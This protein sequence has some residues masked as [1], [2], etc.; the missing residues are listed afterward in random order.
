LLSH[1]I[2]KYKYSLLGLSILLG[3][4]AAC[5][6]EKNTFI[7]R[8]YHSTT[9]KYNGYWNARELIRV[10]LR[11]YRNNYK[12]D[13]YAI[14]PLDLL[15][16]EEDVVDMYPVLDTAISKCMTVISKHS[17][18]TASKPAKKK[19]EYAKW[20]D[21]NWLLIGKSNFYRRDYQKALDNFEFVRKFYGNRSSMYEGMLWKAKCQIELGDI[22]EAKRT[23]QILD[24]NF[25]N[26]LSQKKEKDTSSSKSKKKSKDDD[27]SLPAF[28][29]HLH[30][31]IAKTKAHLALIEND[32]TKAIRFLED[33]IKK[34]KVK[35]EKARL[36]F[37]VGQLLQ[38][39]DDEAAREYYTRAIKL[40]APFEMSFHAKINRATVGGASPEEILADLTKMAK[41]QKYLEYRDQIY[42]AM[43]KVEL[44][45][46]EVA[47]AKTYFTKSAFFSLNNPRQKGVS[48]EKLGDLSFNE[49][50]YV[51]AQRYYD[52]SAQVIP[53]EYIN[54]ELIR[55]KANNLAQL[56]DNIDVVMYEDS[57]QRIALM[58]EKERDKFLKDLVK[59]LQEEERLRREREAQR[60]EEMRKLQQ[61]LA[62]QN[63]GEGNKWYWNNIKNIEEGFNEFRNIWGQR[64][65]ED[66]WRRSNKSPS[67]DFNELAEGDTLVDSIPTKPR[68]AIE[69]LTPETLL[70]DIPLTDSAMAVSNERLLAALYNSGIIYKD[71]LNET[72]FGAKQFQRVIDREIENKHNVL[73]AF[74]LYKIHEGNMN[75]SV[76]YKDYILTNYPNSDYA[77]YLRDPDYFIKKKE[78]DALA[79]Q[80]YLKSVERYE[81]GLYYPVILKADNVINGEPDNKYRGQ[82]LILKAMAMGRVNPDKTTLLP[83]L[84]QAVR[85]FPETVIAEKAQELIGFIKNGIPLFQDFDVVET[86]DLYSYSSKDKLFV[87][88]FLEE[89]DDSRVAQTKIADFNREFFSRYR[90]KTGAQLLD[91]QKAMVVIREFNDANTAREYLKSFERTKKHV[92]DYKSR[93]I[94]FI[95][96][97]NFKVFLKEKDIAVY[98]KFFF[99]NY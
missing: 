36:N 71:Q 43:A 26:Y 91:A 44:A 41:E 35:E 5:S 85:E 9:A 60:A 6:T 30:P 12:E 74:Q 70:A 95:S 24:N 63:Q 39:N 42:F 67:I 20:I 80:D 27:N 99:D 55:S 92:I 48:Y 16:N 32:P 7:N 18:P 62:A 21:Q 13:F 64:D 19:T 37:I 8:T 52:S 78:L 53:D 73:S 66:D 57:V 28:P 90:L 76:V 59:Q 93:K 23:L 65:N 49:R 82:Y 3:I 58:D 38:L 15:P 87:L 46:N 61:Q 75:K 94:L 11:D 81:S 56:V 47:Q 72:E 97:E 1:F 45:R 29:A 14:L 40:N 77:N 22:A 68:T 98:E 89:S 31:E 69:D 17:M 33:A 84:E 51:S 25:N 10:G 4:A 83:T 86:S 34:T 88:V 54:A 79:L 96:S 50:N 2:Q